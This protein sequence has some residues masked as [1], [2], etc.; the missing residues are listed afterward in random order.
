MFFTFAQRHCSRSSLSG[1]SPLTQAHCRRAGSADV[2]RHRTDLRHSRGGLH[3]H[4][5][6]YVSMGEG[7]RGGGSQGFYSGSWDIARLR[8]VGAGESL[9]AD[10][11]S[12]PDDLARTAFHEV[13]GYSGLFDKYLGAMTSLTVS[14]DPAV[15]NISST[16]YRPR[17]DSYHLLRDPVTGDLPWPALLLGLTIVSGWYW[18]SDQVRDQGSGGERGEG[19]ARTVVGGVRWVEPETTW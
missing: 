17:P 7:C 19:R 2:H 9:G 18:C 4:G 3:P 15:G 10:A 13:G 16:C 5:L 1:L 8:R 11:G 6:R 14:E 12:P